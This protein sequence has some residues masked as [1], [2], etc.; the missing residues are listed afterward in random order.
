MTPGDFR[1]ELIKELIP[2]KYRCIVEKG[3]PKSWL[4]MK[5][6]SY[7]LACIPYSEIEADD[8]TNM[9]AK[10]ILRKALHAFPV[11][12]EKGVFILY[13][14]DHENWAANYENFRVD[15]TAL[16]PIIVQAVHFFDPNTG[17]N[18]N[19]RTSWGPIKF[20]F[21]GPTIEKIEEIGNRIRQ[22][23]HS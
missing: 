11:L 15:K 19:K 14:G 8:Y 22:G 9:H 21:C 17:E 2:F 20:G 12:M 1:N 4:V 23:S 7:A 16:R 13:L 5:K 18:A 3:V 6:G 10:S